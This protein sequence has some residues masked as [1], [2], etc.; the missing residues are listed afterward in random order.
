MGSRLELNNARKWEPEPNLGLFSLYSD[1]QCN[2]NGNSVN[3]IVLEK[4][5]A[6]AQGVFDR[7]VRELRK[8]YAGICTVVFFPYDWRLDCDISA[9]RLESYINQNGFTEV[10]LVAHS[11]GGLVSSAYLRR[12]FDRNNTANRDKVKKLITIGTP[13]QGSAKMLEVMSTGEFLDYSWSELQASIAQFALLRQQVKALTPNMKSI[14]Q[15]LLGRNYPGAFAAKR[16]G[17]FE[18]FGIKELSYD[19]TRNE[20]PTL[21]L[22]NQ[23]YL[24]QNLYDNNFGYINSFTRG[25]SHVTDYVDTTRLYG[26]GLETTKTYVFDSLW[27]NRVLYTDSGDGTVLVGSATNIS[28]KNRFGYKDIDHTALMSNPDVIDKVTTIL[29]SVFGPYRS[30]GLETESDIAT[31]NA[32]GWLVDGAGK[33]V[34]IIIE[35][36]ST[37][38]LYNSQDGTSLDVRGDGVYSGVESDAIR[39]GSVWH[40][41]EAEN[42]IQFALKDGDYLVELGNPLLPSSADSVSVYV[43]YQ[44]KGYVQKRFRYSGEQSLNFDTLTVTNHSTKISTVKD[45]SNQTV[46]PSYT[47]SAAELA[48]GNLDSFDSVIAPEAYDHLSN[49]LSPGCLFIRSNGYSDVT[50]ESQMSDINP[51]QPPVGNRSADVAE[52]VTADVSWVIAQIDDMPLPRYVAATAPNN[53]YK[54]TTQ[55]ENGRIYALRPVN[56]RITITSITKPSI[57]VQKVIRDA[58]GEYQFTDIPLT[59]NRLVGA[60]NKW[61]AII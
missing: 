59:F 45:S 15:L 7:I 48:S 60:T 49:M 44:T 54:I 50:F 12:D 29:D 39:L 4:D 56:Y 31:Q 23:Q 13:Y 34:D 8:R 35:G 42:R 58:N 20:L 37:Y 9:E 24:N 43:E 51:P 36:V 11:M 32:R 28:T 26:Y 40:L 18:G 38:T 55:A 27:G 1:L 47:A 2:I 10:A 17:L 19:E 41:N 57:T 46:A 61:S 22:S 53:G 25:S 3:S 30:S 33:Y 5:E 14:Y 21:M 16:E 6:G 52:S